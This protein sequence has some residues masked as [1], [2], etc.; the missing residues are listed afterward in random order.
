[1]F[2]KLKSC[3]VH[4]NVCLAICTHLGVVE[5]G[6]SLKSH[7]LGESVAVKAEEGGGCRGRKGV[8]GVR[9]AGSLMF[10]GSN[11]NY[12]LGGEFSRHKIIRAEIAC[13]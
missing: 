9:T 8:T 2:Y 1:M 3:M 7:I 4:G 13:T 5:D 6:Y 12:G 11:N 10:L